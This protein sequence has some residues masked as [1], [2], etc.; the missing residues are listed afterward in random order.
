MQFDKY[1]E[2]AER[3]CRELVEELLTLG[4]KNL[5]QAC[6]ARGIDTVEAQLR[7]SGSDFLEYVRATPSVR[8]RL[9]H[10]IDKP[11]R[12]VHVMCALF[13]A[14]CGWA[15]L[16][17]ICQRGIVAG[18]GYRMLT[19]QASSAAFD[20]RLNWPSLWPFDDYPDPFDGA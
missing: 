2:A 19:A 8:K 13:Y 17:A 9:L 4:V 6:K 5:H 7:E 14:R 16:H 15:F 11:D 3:H 1:A 18:P 20:L 10:K 12:S